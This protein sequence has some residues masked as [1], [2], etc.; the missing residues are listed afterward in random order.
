MASFLGNEITVARND[1]KVT[2][3]QRSANGTITL[4][5]PQAAI[6]AKCALT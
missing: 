4:R 6:N 3:G 5:V 1:N 2:N